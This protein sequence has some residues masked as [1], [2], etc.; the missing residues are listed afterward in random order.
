MLRTLLCYGSTS[1]HISC[2]AVLE[3][4]SK[5]LCTAVQQYIYEVDSNMKHEVYE[6]VR[7]KCIYCSWRSTFKV[8][9]QR[10][11]TD[12]MEHYTTRRNAS[13][14]DPWVLLLLYHLM[15]YK[16]YTPSVDTSSIVFDLPCSEQN[17]TTAT[18]GSTPYSRFSDLPQFMDMLLLDNTSMCHVC[19]AVSSTAVCK[20]L[21]LK[22]VCT[23]VAL[24]AWGAGG[25]ACRVN[26][27]SYSSYHTCNIINTSYIYGNMRYCCCCTSCFL[28]WVDLVPFEL[29]VCRYP[30]VLLG[31][32]YFVRNLWCIYTLTLAHDLLMKIT[33]SL[34]DV[35][36]L[37]TVTVNTPVR[38]YL[39]A[40]FVYSRILYTK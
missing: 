2:T 14:L 33:P 23:V 5:I 35:V 29:L 11:E 28:V 8:K 40:Y 4:H 39:V 10:T 34:H 37:C 7:M 25:I 3:L 26:N 19:F 20:N 21:K 16:Q 12:G 24:Y 18:D 36:M 15:L 27:T 31:T 30:S 17:E 1:L 9:V 13:M 32:K 38:S 6:R 22:L